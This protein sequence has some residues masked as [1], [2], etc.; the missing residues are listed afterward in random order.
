MLIGSSLQSIEYDK[1]IPGKNTVTKFI[2]YIESLPEGE[3]YLPKDIFLNTMAGKDLSL[4]GKLSSENKIYKFIDGIFLDTKY[5]KQ[6]EAI[7]VN[8][9]L[10]FKG[11]TKDSTKQSKLYTILIR[12]KN[13][14]CNDSE[15]YT[16]YSITGR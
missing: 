8:W 11:T 13:D 2:S 6:G 16:I 9:T 3:A 15:C 1:A 12:L 10:N 4:I 5:N 7:E 14:D